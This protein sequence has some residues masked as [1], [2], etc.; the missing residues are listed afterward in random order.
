MV[1]EKFRTLYVVDPTHDVSIAK[2]YSESVVFISSGDE[3]IED[4]E[5]RM[6]RILFSFDPRQDAIIPMGK[7]TVCLL[8]GIVLG[9]LFPFDKIAFGVYKDGEYKFI[10]VRSN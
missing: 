10:R 8:T 9:R 3:Q 4:L 6:M 1:K 2:D 7:V 5:D